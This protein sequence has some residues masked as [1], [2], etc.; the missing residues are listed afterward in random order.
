MSAGEVTSTCPRCQGCGTITLAADFTKAELASEHRVSLAEHARR[1]RMSPR[2]F[3][4]K[5]RRG[6]MGLV[7]TPG[8]GGVYLTPESSA[9]HVA[10]VQ[11]MRAA[12]RANKK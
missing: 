4:G 5:D 8:P 7:D 3:H 11:E 10:E 12:R 2:S 9:R 1:A 6:Q